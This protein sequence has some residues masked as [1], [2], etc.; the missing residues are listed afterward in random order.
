MRY[1]KWTFWLMLVLLVGGFL[2]YTLPQHDIVRIVGTENRRVDIGGNS[3]FWA[4]SEAG[5]VNST[6]RD[7]FF[8]NAVDAR[9]RPHE[10]RNEDTGWGWPPYFKIDSFGLQTKAKDL[11]STSEAPVWVSVTHYGWRNAFFTIFPNAVGV[12]RVEGPDVTI[13]PWVPIIVLVLLVVLILMIRR[14]FIR[15]RERIVDPAMVRAGR[16][17]NGVSESVEDMRSGARGFG[18]R[19]RGWFGG[20]PKA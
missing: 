10:Y 13:I 16:A 14:M 15:F 18:A 3:I 20:K 5:M 6:S 7:V 1:V 8:I 11:S 9:G 12:K 19:V 4:R 2:H 17:R